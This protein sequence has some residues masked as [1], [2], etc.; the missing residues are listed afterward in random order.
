VSDAVISGE[1]EDDLVG[2]GLPPVVRLLGVAISELLGLAVA[3]V[4]GRLRGIYLGVASLSLVFPGLWLG[5]SP[6]WASTSSGSRPARSSCP[7]PAPGS[8]G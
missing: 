4:A 1:A 2:L 7:R 3:P 8:P 6:P 5:Q